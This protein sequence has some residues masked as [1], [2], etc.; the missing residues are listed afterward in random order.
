MDVEGNIETV[1]NVFDIPVNY[2]NER[3][4]INS[5]SN[6]GL[7]EQWED[8]LKNNPEK[9]YRNIY[10]KL[11]LDLNVSAE[12]DASSPKTHMPPGYVV[13]D[14][15]DAKSKIHIRYMTD[16]ISEVDKCAYAGLSGWI[17]LADIESY[18]CDQEFFAKAKEENPY[19]T[20]I[21][22]LFSNLNHAG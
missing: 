18:V 3:E 14:K 1:G 7:I 4:F 6:A 5:L 20:V 9:F 21:D 11:E 13:I 12:P 17:D 16:G 19:G 22:A 15:T 2:E 8:A 10:L